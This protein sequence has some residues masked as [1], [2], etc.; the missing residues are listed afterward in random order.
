[1]GAWLIM[2]KLINRKIIG[3][4]GFERVNYTITIG[5]MAFERVNY[6]VT[7]TIIRFIETR[8]QYNWYDNKKT[9]MARLTG[10]QVIW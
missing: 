10:W 5:I 9:E 2:K 7:N 8:L 1:M 6:T 4:M 3:I